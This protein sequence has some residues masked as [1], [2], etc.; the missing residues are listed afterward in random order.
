[1]DILR[2]KKAQPPVTLVSPRKR[3]ERKVT[4]AA[5][6]AEDPSAALRPDADVNSGLGTI[7]NAESSTAGIQDSDE[8][9]DS[10]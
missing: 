2:V 1:M 7:T 3:K 9:S 6:I 10:D 8:S 5:A 4:S